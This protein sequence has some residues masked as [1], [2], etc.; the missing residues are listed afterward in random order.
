MSSARFDISAKVP[1]GT[2]KAQ[3]RVMLQNLLTDRFKLVLH[4][5]KKESSIYVLLVAKGGPKLKESAK[6][7]TDGA[8]AAPPPGGQRMDGPG[9]GMMGKDGKPQLPPGV[10]RGTPMMIGE[11]QMIAP[12]GQIRMISN[13]ATIGKFLDV[14]ANQ[15]D[16]PVTD[17]TGLSGTYDITLDFAVDPSIMQAKIAAMG[18]GPPPP[19]IAP[20]EGAAHDPRGA[21]TIFSALTEPVGF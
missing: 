8:V 3:S 19:E 7:S 18:G 21:A 11:G 2:T 12:G 5:S 6:E 1:A 17:M 20:P 14:L 16:R 10:P 13:G 9:R 15:L 4:H